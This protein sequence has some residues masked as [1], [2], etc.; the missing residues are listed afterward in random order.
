[1]SARMTPANTTTRAIVDV[2]FM[3]MRHPPATPAPHLPAGWS[4][5]HEPRPSVA[6]YREL[7]DRVGRDYCWWMR[8]VLP[9]AELA[10]ILAEPG[11][12]VFLLREGKDLR[13]FFELENQPWN[14][15][16]LA[17]FGLFPDAIGH[18]TGRIFLSNAIEI[19]WASRPARVTVNTC[20][21]DHPRALPAY[22]KAG[23]EIRNVVRE[24]WD[25]PDRLG[26]TIPDRLR[27]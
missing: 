18:G 6:F 19:A 25:I 22:L 17:Y 26:L 23:F 9:D 5:T 10:G 16:N 20:N 27:A 2:T 3:E 21:A 13:G 12:R 8:Q 1:M 14:I 24:I 15:I 11:R 4:I 7:Y